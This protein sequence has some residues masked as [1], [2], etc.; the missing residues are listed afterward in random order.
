M[1]NLCFKG[2]TNKS[3]VMLDAVEL[4]LQNGDF[5][6]V[7]PEAVSYFIDTFTD[8]PEEMPIEITWKCCSLMEMGS[9]EYLEVTRYFTDSDV[10][11]FKDCCVTTLFFPEDTIDDYIL[12]IDDV[13]V[14][15]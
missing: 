3:Y 15:S 6:V 9:E 7:C 5:I 13:K 10:P 14:F 1:V 8:D 4:E 11:S 2:I 12:E